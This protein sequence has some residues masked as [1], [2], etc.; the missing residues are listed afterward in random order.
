M[1]ASTVSAQE[2]LGVALEVGEAV[3]GGGVVM[4]GAG[5]ELC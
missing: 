2:R 1:R 5:D 3:G 4:L